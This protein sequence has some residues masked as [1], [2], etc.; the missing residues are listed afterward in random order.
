MTKL[1][2]T[3]FLGQNRSH[4]STSMF[5][6]RKISAGN[7]VHLSSISYLKFWKSHF[8]KNEV[9]TQGVMAATICK[10]NLGESRGFKK[11][12]RFPVS[13]LNRYLKALSHIASK[14]SSFFARFDFCGSRT[15]SQ[16]PPKSKNCAIFMIH[17]T[18]SR[19]PVSV[20]NSFV[21]VKDN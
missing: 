4:L 6:P 19:F 2:T 12:S 18:W 13:A 9:L 5:C 21:Y 7:S 10:T 16:K 11:W 1:Q 17:G 15:T 3:K 8:N 20:I 14:Y